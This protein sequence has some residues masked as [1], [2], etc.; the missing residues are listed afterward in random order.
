[1]I[2][3]VSVHRKD[4][5]LYF[6]YDETDINLKPHMYITFENVHVSLKKQ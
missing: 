4:K 6:R 1:M 2:F 3:G 5:I